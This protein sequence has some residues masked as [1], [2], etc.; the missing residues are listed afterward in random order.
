MTPVIDLEK[1]TDC[2]LCIKDCISKAIVSGTKEILPDKCNL[3]GHCTAVCPEGAVSIGGRRGEEIKPLPQ[4]FPNYFDTLVR[5]R[6]SV[7]NYR[8]QNVTDEHVDKI[9]KTTVHAP[10]GTNSRKTA[11]T[12]LN[13]REKI[14]QLSDIVM[15]HFKIVTRLIFN[16]LTYP[17]LLLLYGKKQTKKYFSYKKMISE[18]GQGR[19][20]LTYDAPLLMIFHVDRKSSTPGQ[21]GIIWATTAMYTAESLGIG[22]CFNGFLVIGIN[23]CRKARKFLNIPK[24]H[25]I[26][27][28][29]TAGYPDFSYKRYTIKEDLNVNFLK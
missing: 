19:N 5:K 21:D 13:S 22:T 11:V 20:T 23:T 9:L 24:G 18:Y 14:N 8:K 26:Y 27:E 10:T 15:D 17:F 1:C 29:F 25:K 3:C 12:V 16:P 7:R 2:R 4:E 28:T 6:R